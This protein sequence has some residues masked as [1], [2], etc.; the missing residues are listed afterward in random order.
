MNVNS[1]NETSILEKKVNQASTDAEKACAIADLAWGIKYSNPARAIELGDQAIELSLSIDLESNLPKC[2]LSKAMGLLHMS[3]FQAAEKSAQLGLSGYKKLDNQAGVRHALNVI[4]SIYFRWGNYADALEN[5]LE[6]LEIHNKLS[7]TPDPGILSNIGA[8]YLQLGDTD[9]A[10]DC[11]TQVKILADRV[12]GPADLKTATCVNMGEIYSR[13]GM[14]DD[15]LEYLTEGYEICLRNDMK[16]AVAATT[17]EI[18]TV[19]IELGRYNEAM[20][21]FREAISSFRALDDLKGEAL[22]LL[23]MGKCCFAE[24][25]GKAMEFYLDSLKRFRSLKDNQGIAEALTGISMVMLELGRKDVALDKLD[26][27]YMIARKEG[28]K[29]QLS[30]IHRN[31]ASI[32]ESEGK[33]D[34]AFE[35]LKLYHEVENHLRSERVANRLRSLRVIHHVEQAREEVT[36]YIL[37]NIKLEKDK[38]KLEMILRNRTE[39]LEKDSVM[40]EIPPDTGKQ[41]EG[42]TDS[43][44]E[45]Q[46][47]SDHVSRIA[48]DLNDVLTF[49]A[50]NAE[51]ALADNTLTEKTKK[52]LNLTIDSIRDGVPL[53][54]L[55]SSLCS[56]EDDDAEVSES[57]PIDAFRNEPVNK[58]K[59]GSKVLVVED[60]PGIREELVT[61][62]EE[63]GY[64]VLASTSLMNAKEIISQSINDIGCI[65][66][67]VVLDDGS[68]IDLIRDAHEQKP[69]LPILAGS[70]YPL[71]RGDMEYL[72]KDGIS[73]VQKPYKIDNL[74]LK[75]STIL[76]L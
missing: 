25:S 4:G 11:Y 48:N 42:G 26:E 49:A 10:L 52:H 56:S 38:S 59:I 71:S 57:T 70:S 72:K 24:G 51:Q 46:M 45:L 31:L 5:Y 29:P 34:T 6:S 35:H 53:S 12:N 39:E 13:M 8:V 7:D 41:S 30:D 18:G 43:E 54:M 32:L 76:P 15:A 58:Y 14:F 62:L 9:R 40:Q 60:A 36:K 47:F 69:L 19:L 22:V 23:N 3:R 65:L 33:F 67:D 28:L 74:L 73:L 75:L 21:N 44:R 1:N 50:E 64:S 37:Q 16:Q 63:Y 17:D 2:Y 66:V 27:A 20:K 68:G 61:S 55:L